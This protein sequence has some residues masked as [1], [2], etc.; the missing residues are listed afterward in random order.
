[1]HRTGAEFELSVLE[2]FNLTDYLAALLDNDNVGFLR[3][4]SS[5]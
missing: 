3:A 2:A 5:G 4:G 1:L